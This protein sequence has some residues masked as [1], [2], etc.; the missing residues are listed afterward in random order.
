MEA[1]R[2]RLKDMNFS[3][4]APKVEI[5]DA[6]HQK[7]RGMIFHRVKS[8]GHYH[9][10]LSMQRAVWTYFNGEIPDDDV[11]HI[12]H[13][14]GNTDNNDIENLAL[15]TR[16]EH[17]K[18]HAPQFVEANKKRAKV[19]REKAPRIKVFETRECVLRKKV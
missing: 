6:D 9:H 15:I 13:I 10:V 5:I 12:H 3:I 16:S 17:G 18:I 1:H 19:Q 4:D 8:R 14:D 7:F 11:Y 2:E